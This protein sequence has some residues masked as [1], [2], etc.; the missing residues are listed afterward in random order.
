MK[1]TLFLLGLLAC[2]FS[3]VRPARADS[4]ALNFNV[5]SDSTAAVVSTD[6]ADLP[7]HEPAETN[8][9][10][11]ASSDDSTEPPPV[12]SAE[13][14]P[15]TPSVALQFA[16]SEEVAIVQSQEIAQ[17]LADPDPRLESPSA[18]SPV[19]KL[20]EPTMVRKAENSSEEL[21][22]TDLILAQ[23]PAEAAVN[24]EEQAILF[25]GGSNSLV[26]RTVGAAE[27]NL[28][29]DGRK[30]D[31]YYGHVD[32]GNGVWNRGTFSY[33]FGNAENLSPQ[34]ADARQLAKIKGHYEHS[35]LPKAKQLGLELS[36]AETLNAIDLANQAPLAVT[37]SGGFVE[38]LAEAKQQ[39]GLSGET[40]ILEGRVW[41]FWNPDKQ[42]WDAP[43][44][45]A[46][47]DISKQESIRRDQ[48][49]RMLAIA[50]ALA[51]YQQAAQK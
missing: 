45:R 7:N 5:A 50:D 41:A 40:A 10:T 18:P 9:L 44:L 22:E 37:E 15:V 43:G 30:T 29:A 21:T 49:R 38:R 6:S 16:P 51:N 1:L 8:Q 11:H 48:E 19:P 23:K 25:A 13:P 31:N 35:V 12:P 14:E 47:D 3:A 4:I 36:L 42:G 2:L 26:A 34:E 20:V 32:P 33:Q 39:K 28:T 27:G 24:P 17:P 46:Y